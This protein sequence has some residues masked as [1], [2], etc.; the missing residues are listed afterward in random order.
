VVVILWF[1]VFLAETNRSPFDFSEGESELVSGFNLEFGGFMFAILFM[2][3]YGNIIFLCLLSVYMF[4]GGGV[5]RLV[6]LLLVGL[7]LLVR[8]TLV[9]FRYDNLIMLA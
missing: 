9:R 5:V 3:E 4:I 1:V 7:C 6:G 2:A 8:G